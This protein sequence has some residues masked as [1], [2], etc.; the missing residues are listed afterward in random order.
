ML[1]S[2]RKGADRITGRTRTDD[3]P[4]KRGIGDVDIWSVV[5]LHHP[6][7]REP[8][9]AEY[10]ASD[11]VIEVVADLLEVS[12]SGPDTPL[13]L[14]L[15]NMLVNPARENSEIGWHRDLVSTSQPPELELAELRKAT[16]AVQWNTALYEDTC[17]LIVP[18]RHKRAS[19]EQERAVVAHRPKD[20][21]P[22]PDDGGTGSRP[23]RILQR[24][25]ASQGPI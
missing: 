16:Y 15:V 5:H 18:G 4:H 19:T 23:R 1:E 12:S 21:L 14:E 17:L 10:M 6:D 3:W 24:Q 22:W 25:P 13:Q 20:D 8:V 9:L 7:V 2:L 11:Q